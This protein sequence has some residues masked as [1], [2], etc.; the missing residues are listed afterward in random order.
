MLLLLNF[1]NLFYKIFMNFYYA[2][3]DTM[4]NIMILSFSVFTFF[5]IYRLKLYLYL[6][7]FINSDFVYLLYDTNYNNV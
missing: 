1:N 7:I 4:Q 2:K 6:N 3:F 5:D